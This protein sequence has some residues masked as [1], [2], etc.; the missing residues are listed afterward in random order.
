MVRPPPEPKM[1][2]FGLMGAVLGSGHIAP[3]V[4]TD[5]TAN[6]TPYCAYS[7]CS[8][9]GRGRSVGDPAPESAAAAPAA[10]S[11]AASI[12]ARRTRAGTALTWITVSQH[13]S[14]EKIRAC[15]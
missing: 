8:G 11:A 9:G 6:A 3:G 7:T 15:R 13:F 10:D 4:I 2:G 14:P 12:E 1:Q 5:S